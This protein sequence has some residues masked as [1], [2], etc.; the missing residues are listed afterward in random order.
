MCGSFLG[1]N[2]FHGG[3]VGR[4]AFRGGVFGRSACH[5]G[6]VCRSSFHGYLF[7]RIFFRGLFGRISFRRGGISETLFSP[8]NEKCERRPR[9]AV[10][11]PCGPRTFLLFLAG[12]SCQLSKSGPVSGHVHL[13]W[14][15]RLVSMSQ[16]FHLFAHVL[17]LHEI[18]RNG[19]QSQQAPFGA[20]KEH[21]RDTGLRQTLGEKLST[22]TGVDPNGG[23]WGFT[24][25]LDVCSLTFV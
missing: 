19:R 5:G 18:G 25:P 9:D 13:F 10:F 12:F 21:L 22:N 1:R 3:L 8:R 4:I 17:F 11:R 20:R 24:S 15:L 6:L 14:R 23:D 2:Y 7:G 16:K